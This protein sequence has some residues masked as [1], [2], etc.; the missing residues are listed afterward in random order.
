MFIDSG[1]VCLFHN[2][3]AKACILLTDRCAQ[4]PVGR[5]EDPS[6]GC[7]EFSNPRSNINSRSD[8]YR[9]EKA[10]ARIN[11]MG[12]WTASE[13]SSRMKGMFIMIVTG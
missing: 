2:Y 11:T 10:Q 1:Y 13:R 12:W 5:R 6:V 9:L 7:C 8:N 4:V 3:A